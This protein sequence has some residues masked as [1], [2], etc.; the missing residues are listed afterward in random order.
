M[1]ILK[2]LLIGTFIFSYNNI[3]AQEE[4][5]AEN[6]NG[7]KFTDVKRLP[8]TTVKNQYRAGTCWSYSGISFLE[9]EI[10]R[11]GKSEVDLSEMWVVRHA[12]NDKA[13]KYVRLHGILNFG[14][15][16]AFHDVTEMIREYG[17]VPQEKY[18]GLNYGTEKDVHGEIDKILTSYVKAVVEDEN[19]QITPVWLKGYN[20]VLDT[21]FGA[22]IKDFDLNGKK[23]TPANYTKELGLN[24][25]D[26][27]EI[28]SFTH[29]PFYTSFPIEVQDNWMWG[30]VYN[31]PLD[32]FMQVFD[33]AINTGYTIAWGADVSEKGFSWTKGIAVV[34]DENVENLDN[35]ERSRWSSLSE[36]E[37]KKLFYELNKP[38]KEKQITQEIRQISF[39][40]YETTDDHGMHIIG[41]SK[42]QNGTK[43]YIVKN[44]WSDKGSP[45]AGYFYASETFV[46]Y[47]TMDIMVH[48]NAIPA[49]IKNKLGI[50]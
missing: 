11:M 50:K 2:L 7:Y 45:Y 37:Q 23:F 42:D 36:K 14:Q 17:I 44:S 22:E 33:N 13:D 9:S 18:Q 39:N 38:A 27:V 25:D 43:Y 16:G 19:K 1:R 46:K 8:T 32:E 31:L 35:D 5:I 4:N 47:K 48:K 6:D 15:G 20:A 49:A 29:H 41:I 12:Y 21:Y 10:I 3:F 40:N 26:Y 34:P 28:T 30:S 24:I